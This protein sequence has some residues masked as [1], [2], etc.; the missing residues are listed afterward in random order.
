MDAV[1]SP[2]T[3]AIPGALPPSSPSGVGG[4]SHYSE[5]RIPT[6]SAI[7]WVPDDAPCPAD[8]SHPIFIS[9]RALAAVHAHVAAQ[10]DGVG[11]LGF[12]VGGLFLSSETG[13]PYIAIESTIR[14]PWSAGGDDLKPALLQRRASAEEELRGTGGRLLGWYHSRGGADAKL[15][16]ADLDAHL[17]CFDQPWHVALVVA[18]GADV[19]GGVFRVAPDA[20]WSNQ[21]LPFVELLDGDALLADGGRIA[22]LG[23]TNYRRAENIT[24][25][26]AASQPLLEAKS[27]LL[28]PVAAESE[29]DG[30]SP[31]ASWRLPLEQVLRVA[32]YGAL[33][34]VTAGALFGVYRAAAS[35]S[36]RG[37]A[38]A[39]ARSATVV[40]EPGVIDRLADTVAFAVDAYELRARLFDG[41][42][43]TCADLARGLVDLEE[44]WTAYSTARAATGALDSARNARDRALDA[45]VG[46]AERGFERSACPRP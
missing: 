33:G 22:Y 19:R 20:P 30:V 34:M 23:W 39:A 26:N 9:Q 1:R 28:F 37:A 45:D 4:E 13:T 15:S 11:S 41:R 46:A 40:A 16:P 5:R 25:S 21:R 27:R 17:A 18:R 2:A 14:I 3:Y 42:K 8:I 36:G 43:M 31:R 38:V 6:A 44:R 32:G 10:P 35:G 7:L 24:P 29:A 12:L